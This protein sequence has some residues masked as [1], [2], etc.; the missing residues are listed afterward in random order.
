MLERSSSSW[1]FIRSESL[2]LSLSVYCIPKSEN[3]CA[4]LCVMLFNH[5]GAVDMEKSNPKWW[6]FEVNWVEIDRQ[7]QLKGTETNFPPEYDHSERFDMTNMWKENWKFTSDII[8]SIVSTTEQRKNT[9]PPIFQPWIFQMQ[10][11]KWRKISSY[12]FRWMS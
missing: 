7:Q 4:P 9:Q 11:A 6:L 5:F 1:F 12:C 3:V 2:A 8:E 10:R